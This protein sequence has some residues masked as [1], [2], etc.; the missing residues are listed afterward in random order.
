MIYLNLGIQIV[1]FI[2]CIASY[3][4][5]DLLNLMNT[6]MILENLSLQVRFCDFENLKEKNLELYWRSSCLRFMGMTLNHT[7]ILLNSK[8]S[9]CRTAMYILLSA[10]VDLVFTLIG[11]Y[12]FKLKNYDHF[13]MKML[14]DEFIIPRVGGFIIIN[15]II[16]NFDT[17]N[18]YMISQMNERLD[19]QNKFK[20]ILEN[21]QESILIYSKNDIEYINNH[22]FQ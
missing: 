8:M 2:I 3:F 15:A 20:I 14:D 4:K 12:N 13:N 11:L 18:D 7:L 9:R 1:I 21:L 17:G 6:L 10:L 5:P 16:A 19:Q 22:S